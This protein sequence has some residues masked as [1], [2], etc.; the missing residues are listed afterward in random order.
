M[1][2]YLARVLVLSFIFVLLPS[3]SHPA[4]AITYNEIVQAQTGK[5]LGENISFPYPSSSLVNEN[6]TIY[7]IC[8]VSK[9]PFTNYQAFQGLGYSLRNVVNGDLSA[10]TPTTSYFITTAQAGHPW[11]SWLL[12]NGTVYYSHETGLIPV[13]S[14]E[15]FLN[16]GGQTKYIVRANSY[17]IKALNTNPNLPLL[18]PSDARIYRAPQS[19]T[20]ASA[21]QNQSTP[22]PA[23]VQPTNYCPQDAMLCSDGSHVSRSGSACSFTACPAIATSTPVIVPPPIATSPIF[24][25]KN[26]GTP[27]L[28]KNDILIGVHLNDEFIKEAGNDATWWSNTYENHTLG[29]NINNFQWVDFWHW[30]FN[31][32]PNGPIQAG[33]AN[34]KKLDQIKANLQELHAQGFKT[35]LLVAGSPAWT[36]TTY[37]QDYFAPPDNMQ[38]WQNYSYY[39]ANKLNGLVDMYVLGG[40]ANHDTSKW[41]P[42]IYAAYIKAGFIGIK[43]AD[44][45]AFVVAGDTTPTSKASLRTWYQNVISKAKGYFDGIAFNQFEQGLG[46]NG[47]SSWAEEY[48]DLRSML[49]TSGLTNIDI[50]LGEAG[51]S[52]FNTQVPSYTEEYQSRVLNDDVGGVLTAGMNKVVTHAIDRNPRYWNDGGGTLGLTKFLN[53][54]SAWPSN[55]VVNGTEKNSLVNVYNNGGGSVAQWPQISQALDSNGNG[56]WVNFSRFH[57]A[58]TVYTFWSQLSKNG[59]PATRAS[60]TASTS[61]AGKFYYAAS[62]NTTDNSYTLLVYQENFGNLVLDLPAVGQSGTT[63]NISFQNDTIPFNTGER[64]L[65]FNTTENKVV[66]NGIVHIEKANLS[67]FSTIK[68][69]FTNTPVPPPTLVLGDPTGVTATIAACPSRSVAINWTAGNNATHYVIDRNQDNAG[70]AAINVT[71]NVTTYTDSSAK[72]GYSYIYYVQSVYHAGLADQIASF[73]LIPAPPVTITACGQ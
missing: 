47:Y 3:Y 65:N 71:G 6:G 35:S 62:N 17:D 70:I 5:I 25:I 34:D 11:C 7:F 39:L 32:E 49:D 14:W 37:P 73:N 63:A 48:S 19:Q 57:P 24:D 55:T 1:K 64:L 59:K 45:T 2:K 29:N 56:R 30:W 15:I 40:E 9:I 28:S 22:P 21:P 54:N 10:Y 38:A 51:T 69:T 68:I 43:S 23:P 44:K 33:D 58:W 27:R 16:N 12:Y 8:G 60:L 18:Q 42:D 20:A 36:R 31:A 50:Q 26:I 46:D 4:E 41:T 67:G 72:V 66:A 61:G 52:W 13:P 53:I